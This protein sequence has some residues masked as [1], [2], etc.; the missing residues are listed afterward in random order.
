MSSDWQYCITIERNEWAE[1]EQWC[2][3]HIGEFG[4]DWYKLGMDPAE[5]LIHDRTRTIWYF[6]QHEHAVLFK[7]KWA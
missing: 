1:T 5:Y 3:T 7:L 6:R 2:K 4:R